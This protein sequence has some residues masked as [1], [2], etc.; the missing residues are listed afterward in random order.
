MKT[1][2]AK[3][4]KCGTEFE[5]TQKEITPAFNIDESYSAHFITLTAHIKC[6][7]CGLTLTTAYAQLRLIEYQGNDTDDKR[8]EDTDKCSD[9][10]YYT[11]K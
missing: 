11:K 1:Y 8:A 3:C 4:P 10:Y 2:K 6:P 5:F 9:G 7:K